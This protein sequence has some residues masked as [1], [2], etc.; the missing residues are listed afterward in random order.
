MQLHSTPPHLIS[1]C[2]DASGEYAAGQVARAA[3]IL[4]DH[5]DETSGECD[6]SVWYMLL[7]IYQNLGQQRA[8]EKL[9]VFFAKLFQASPPS[10]REPR[11]L[12][13]DAKAR[14]TLGRNA[15]V[16]TGSINQIHAD[17]LRDFVLAAREFKDARI[18]LS[19]MRLEDDEGERR[20]SLEGLLSIMRRLRR[21]HTLTLLMG[22]NQIMDYARTRISSR[23]PE[24][25]SEGPYWSILL[26]VAQWRGQQEIFENLALEYASLFLYC[27]VGFEKDQAIAIAP[28][29][30][31][32]ALID[33]S[34]APSPEVI[35]PDV[36]DASNVELLCRSA[37]DALRAHA[38][39]TLDFGFTS[40]VSPDAA[41]LLLEY[42]KAQDKD[43]EIV[44]VDPN[45]MVRC[46]L[47]SVGIFDFARLHPRPR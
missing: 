24:L 38:S 19:R 36:L 29:E 21:H 14:Q 15:L 35:A 1:V 40:R 27:P 30:D 46:I 31:V 9:A 44:F 17:K 6:S 39:V 8:F 45:E 16:V 4:V 10:W 5:I 25:A 11:Q 13:K 42:V 28:T 22:E 37:D 12:P 20:D 34:P 3:D 23:S 47:E 43:M 32:A 18:D 41:Q 33:P 7:D 2:L 26:E